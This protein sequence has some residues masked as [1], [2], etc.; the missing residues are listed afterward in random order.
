MTA[1]TIH[2]GM[3]NENQNQW[4]IRYNCIFQ[5]RGFTEHSDQNGW[6]KWN[7]SLAKWIY[8]A[9]IIEEHATESMTKKKK[10]KNDQKI[11]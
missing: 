6:M 7:K 2:G 5:R 3:A 8:K 1:D 10:K 9:S 11:Q 4:N